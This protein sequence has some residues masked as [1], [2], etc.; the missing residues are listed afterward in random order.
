MNEKRVV[1]ITGASSGIGA[2]LAKIYAGKGASLV[3]VARRV[4]KLEQVKADCE[5]IDSEA[6][7]VCVGGDVRLKSD[8]DVTVQK[9]I[10]AF[11]QLDTVYANA[12][13]SVDGTVET[14]TREDCERQFDT[15]IYG[16]L[17]TIWASLQE[18]KKTKG[19]LAITGSVSSY[20]SWPGT[21][22]YGM[23]KYAVR[24]LAEAMHGELKP[25]GVSV[26]L[27][28]PGFVNTDF[29]RVDRMGNTRD[30]RPDGLP[31][32]LFVKTERAAKK[33]VRAVESRKAEIVITGHGKILVWLKRFMPGLLR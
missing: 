11:G 8:M 18:L 26:T 2:Q 12:G 29:H 17:N 16:V 30:K 10:E 13:F 1:L 32:W 31:L 20:V 3:L 25:Y 4:E 23:S 5:K 21:S 33:M 15:N 7:V 28:C 6:K 14:M 9:T 27:L 19:R 22:A 24:A